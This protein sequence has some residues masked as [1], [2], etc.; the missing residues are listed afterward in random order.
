MTTASAVLR[1]LHRI[2]RQLADLR[3]RLVRGPKQIVAAEGNVKRAEGELVQAKDAYR[4]ARLASDEK[5]LQLKQRE[6]RIVDLQGKLNAC[7]TNREYQALKEQIA[8]DLQANS[9]LSDEI[10]EGLEQLDLLQAAVKSAETNLVKIKEELQRVRERVADQQTLLE[11]ELARVQAELTSSE[12]YLPEE[13]RADY[14]R[15]APV[16]GEQCLAQLDQQTCGGCY[17]TVTAQTLNDLLLGRPVV[18]K[19]CGCLL[20][21]PEDRSPEPASKRRS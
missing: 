1:E 6:A 20:Y 5:Q 16:V 9:V 13:F 2:H 19:N 15:L 7:S 11:T 14:Q 17:T 12:K 8:A 3:D 21:L 10:L 18:C 4:K